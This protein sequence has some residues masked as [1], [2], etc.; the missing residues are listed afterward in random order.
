MNALR[1]KSGG[2]SGGESWKADLS[3][4]SAWLK[5]FQTAY[6]HFNPAG[7]KSLQEQ[8]DSLMKKLLKDYDNYKKT[9]EKAFTTVDK[10]MEE[11][12]ERVTSQGRITCCEA[13]F[14]NVLTSK[15]AE[16]TKAS[17]VA[18]RV[19]KMTSH[20]IGSSNILPQ[21]WAHVSALL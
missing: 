21:I 11:D 8:L 9:A 12:M 2:G 5:I 4:S 19:A 16:P 7:E 10:D 18:A 17:Q 14:V 13:F 3:D 6:I 15:D 1:Q 20:K